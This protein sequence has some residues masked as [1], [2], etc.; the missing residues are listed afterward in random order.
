MSSGP[1][2][3]ANRPLW[4]AVLRAIREARGVNQSGWA[5]QLGVSLATVGR[6]ESGVTVPNGEIEVAIVD[7]CR[8][9]GLFR[10]FEQGPL[11][12]QIL[13][14][15]L[16]R[17]LLARA[18]MS[19]DP[20]SSVTE[21]P[22]AVPEA[23]VVAPPPVVVPVSQAPPSNLP[24]V[25]TSFIGREGALGELTRLLSTARLVTLS[26]PGGCGKTRL[27]LELA[28]AVRDTYPDGVYLVTL[29]S[30]FEP[31]LV[32]L[33]IAQTLGIVESPGQSLKDSLVSF[34]REKSLLMVLDNFEQVI[35]ASPLVTELLAACPR[36]VVVATSRILLR[37]RGEHEFAV[38]PL[39][40]PLLDSRGQ[41]NGSTPDPLEF[42]AVR[43]FVERAQAARADFTVTEGTAALVA[44]ICHRL[45][46][47]PLAIELAAARTKVLTPA[48]M[49]ERLVGARGRAPLQLLTGGARD[50]PERHQTLR[51]AIAWSYGLLD[52]DERALFRRMAVFA[53]GCTVEAVEAVCGDTGSLDPL[54]G[55]EALVTKSLLWQEEQAGGEMSFFMLDTIREY[56]LDRLSEEDD[57]EVV[58]R[59]HA[60]YYLAIAEES[61]TALRSSARA[62]A[63]QRLAQE[64]D[65]LRTALTWFVEQEDTGAAM[66]LAGALHWWYRWE[67]PSEGRLSGERVLALPGASERTG[68]R[69]AA[70]YL[71]GDMIRAQGNQ[72]DAREWLSES[73]A[74]WREV[75]VADGTGAAR[76]LAYA[77]ASLAWSSLSDPAAAVA[78]LDESVAMLRAANDVWGLAFALHVR[79][80]ALIGRDDDAAA[81]A[82][83]EESVTLHRRHGDPWLLGLGL[84]HL[85]RLA[86]QR[87][88][89]QAAI[90]RLN[91]CLPLFQETGDKFSVMTSLH[92]LG[93]V[94]RDQ[95]DVE[96][97]F[98]RCTASLDLSRREGFVIGVAANL[99]T[100]AGVL[101]RSGEP[102]L[103]AQLYGAAHAIREAMDYP[104]PAFR[105][106]YQQR[107]DATRALLGAAAFEAAWNAGATLTLD[108]AVTALMAASER[109]A[110]ATAE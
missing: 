35:E 12:G 67:S 51:S 32:G 9:R 81:W 16:L 36:L 10:A 47:L 4:S 92:D 54:D 66:A 33:T 106:I 60:A 18:R 40:L 88:D 69:A 104:L 7:I 56:G 49:L 58:S 57:R 109:I 84:Q 48:A 43:L 38:R 37:L 85:A 70:L 14:E 19:H 110:H 17:D 13:T 71:I 80:L 99:E 39:P 79:G 20:A 74:I 44:Q 100:L 34:L 105:A 94:A 24:V 95:G 65:N 53:G 3:R 75:V 62:D 77:Q 45:D 64:R 82:A 25:L 31:E 86:T 22:A 11:Q 5:T 97:A 41:T 90:T 27:A 107:V 55:V 63:A 73:V 30:V 78:L 26:G 101:S 108:Q 91:A 28:T 46:G 93:M 50:L 96:Q 23:P 8:A 59:R 52:P 98:G 6:W 76:G 83:L 87:G 68:V 29:A 1:P 15:E 72:R 102:H 21:A 2:L 42:P 103:A 61:G 89:Y